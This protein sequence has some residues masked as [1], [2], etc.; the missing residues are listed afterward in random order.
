VSDSTNDRIVSIHHLT[1]A[2]NQMNE[3]ISQLTNQQYQV[4][5]PELIH[6]DQNLI[7][8]TTSA[9]IQQFLK[10]QLSAFHP[11]MN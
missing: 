4:N 10:H 3:M 2:T 1:I 11:R 8:M 6:L 7:L 5:S 9:Q